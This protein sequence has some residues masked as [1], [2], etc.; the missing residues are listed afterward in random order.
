M[1][2]T[3]ATTSTCAAMWPSSG[4]VLRSLRLRERQLD[5]LGAD[6][7]VADRDRVAGRR[8]AAHE[9]ERDRPVPRGLDDRA[10]P[11]RPRARRAAAARRPRRGR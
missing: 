5:D 7:A 1:A 8:L 3:V 10:E 11:S 9:R 2:V 4:D 6:A